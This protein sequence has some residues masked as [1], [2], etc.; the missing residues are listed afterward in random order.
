MSEKKRLLVFI[1]GVIVLLS[2]TALAIWSGLQKDDEQEFDP[3]PAP[4][5]VPLR[6]KS[7]HQRI[8]MTSG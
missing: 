3:A 2:V 7:F 6:K 8:Q 4:V 1:I 5:E